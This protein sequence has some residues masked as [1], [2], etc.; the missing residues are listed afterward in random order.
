VKIFIFYSRRIAIVIEFSFLYFLSNEFACRIFNFQF[1]EHIFWGGN[2][3]FI[4]V[5]GKQIFLWYFGIFFESMD[6][7]FLSERS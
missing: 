3:G 6:I 7:L 1:E 5:G 2:Y 4:I